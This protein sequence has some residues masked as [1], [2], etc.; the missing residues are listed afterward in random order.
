[1]LIDTDITIAYKCS[2]CGSFKFSSLSIFKLPFSM[3]RSLHCSCGKS[4]ATISVNNLREYK[5]KIPCIGCGED[6]VF[7]LNVKEFLYKDINV[8]SCPRTAIQQC[9]VG[10]EAVVRKWIDNLEKELDK[11]IDEFGY[12]NYFKNTQ[13]M[14]DTLNRV[15]DIAE[16]GN[17]ICECGNKDIQ[18]VMFSDRIL[19]KCKR[20]PGSRIIYAAS[21]GDLKDVL[22]KQ[23]ILLSSELCDYVAKRPDSFV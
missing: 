7:T 19:L 10:R 13:V 11:I 8:F 22:M 17:L 4:T 12:D 21:N 6:H 18:L 9:F 23:Q 15:H 14:F 20:C 16:E 5:I 1:M 3:D 2:A